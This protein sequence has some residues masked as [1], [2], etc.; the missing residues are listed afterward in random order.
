MR[1]FFTAVIVG[2]AFTASLAC[3]A[4]IP[5][6]ETEIGTAAI[7]LLGPG[8]LA[9]FSF[10]SGRTHDLS[11]WTFTVTLNAVFYSLVAYGVLRLVWS[12]RTRVARH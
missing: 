7:F 11:F 8:I 1:T 10:G 9:G 3:L 6:A 4:A 12:R 5:R 2:C